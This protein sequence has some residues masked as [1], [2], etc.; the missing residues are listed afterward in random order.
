LQK[1]VGDR[2]SDEDMMV[3][4]ADGARALDRREAAYAKRSARWGLADWFRAG[5]QSEARAGPRLWYL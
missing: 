5:G 1:Q 3:I 4:A 2:L